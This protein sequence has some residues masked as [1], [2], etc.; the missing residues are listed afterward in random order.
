M[1]RLATG[2]WI[3]QRQHVLLVGSTG[4]GK[5]YLACALG[6]HACRNGYAVVY[7]RVPRLLHELQVA[8]GDGSLPRLLARWAK[9]DV[10]ILD[11]TTGAWR[12]SGRLSARTS[13][14]SSRTVMASAPPSSPRSCR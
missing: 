14:R 6:Q 13:S 4:S 5:T 9:T 11:S 10:L 7:R 2:E 3:R 8:R 1:R 12:P